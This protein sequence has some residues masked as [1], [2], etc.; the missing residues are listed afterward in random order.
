MFGNNVTFSVWRKNKINKD[1]FLGEICFFSVEMYLHYVLTLDNI[2]YFV[3]YIIC[4]LHAFKQ[5]DW[6]Q[7]GLLPILEGYVQTNRHI[8][9]LESD[10]HNLFVIILCFSEKTA[11][12]WL[13]WMEIADKIKPFVIM[14]QSRLLKQLI[15]FNLSDNEVLI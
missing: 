2:N 6:L 10:M 7:V 11:S 8:H 1:F 3:E 4:E 13:E 5:G 9:M 12:W 14:V 15:V